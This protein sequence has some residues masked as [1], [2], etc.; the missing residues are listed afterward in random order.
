MSTI[1]EEKFDR[2][3]KEIERKL[4]DLLSSIPGETHLTDVYGFLKLM[5]EYKAKYNGGSKKSYET[6]FVEVMH[7]VVNECEKG[8]PPWLGKSVVENLW[9]E[10][11][12]TAD[13]EQENLDKIK[14]YIN[15]RIRVITE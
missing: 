15:Y 14:D 8:A 10:Y 1:L 3:K 7:Y 11:I 12:K 6:G 13:F 4:G 5:K 9:K 2:E